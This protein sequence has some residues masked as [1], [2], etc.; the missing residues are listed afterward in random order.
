[1]HLAGVERQRCA[2]AR[3]RPAK[4]VFGPLSHDSIDRALRGLASL[5]PP[6]IIAV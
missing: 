2:Y 6:F 4:L 1:M 3:Y 5:Q